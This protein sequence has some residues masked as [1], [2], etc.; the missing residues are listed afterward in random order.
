M[1]PVAHTSNLNTAVGAP[2]EI[3]RMKLPGTNRLIDV[4]TKTGAISTYTS[5]LALIP[6][7]GVGFVAMASGPGSWTI[8]A[9]LVGQILLPA[10]EEAAR[11][12]AEKV[13][14]GTYA[15]TDP[16]I[17]SQLTLTTD[18][19]KPGLGVTNYVSNGTDILQGYIEL[20]AGGG[21]SK[22]ELSMRLYPTNLDTQEANGDKKSAWRAVLEYT[23]GPITPPQVFDFSCATWVSVDTTM[24]GSVAFDDFVITVGAAG[25]IS[26][27]PRFFRIILERT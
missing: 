23:G 24:Y 10:V 27:E 17:N 25:A 5:V 4:Y 13:Y 21:I 20:L 16:Q 15:S 7:W 14:S 12:D 18:P 3:V 22:S 2:W 6:D 1:K 11:E 19:S 8:P 9:E 26:V